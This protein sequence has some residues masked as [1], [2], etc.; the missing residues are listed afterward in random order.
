MSN[1]LEVLV[2]GAGKIAQEYV[3]VLIALDTKPIV[4]TRGVNKAELINSLFENITVITGGIESFL[5]NNST[6]PDYAIVATP[7]PT[8]FNISRLLI[9]SGVRNIL[10]EKPG[11][12]NYQHAMELS[13]MA[14]I[15]GSK[16]SI[17]FNRRAFQSV[18]RAKEIIENDGGIVS[19]HFDFSEAIYRQSEKDLARYDE[20]SLS[21][22]GIANS[23]HVIDLAFYLLG[24]IKHLKTARYG[25]DITWH[26]NGSIFMGFGE[27]LNG[28]PFSYH[29][30]WNC[31]G[32]WRIEVM[33]SH[34][35]L[36]FSP[37]EQLSQQTLHS[38][39]IED[40][41]IDTVIDNKYKPGYC[42]QVKRFIEGNGIFDLHELSSS[43]ITFNRI[44][45][46]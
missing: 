17:G 19:M 27:S 40:V 4:V 38:F 8:L 31:P 36:I 14:K 9:E 35:K 22:W 20:E 37:L 30:N 26:K 5:S 25:D 6:L 16:V 39:H 2:V 1:H 33:T 43:I 23:S 45:G 32:R 12:F 42:L 15:H 28:V 11:V 10:I 3:K 29:S 46:Y 13:E 21:Y 41:K 34:R 18:Q 7:A 44:F 24:P